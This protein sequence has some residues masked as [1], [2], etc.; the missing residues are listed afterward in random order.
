MSVMQGSNRNGIVAA[1]LASLILAITASTAANAESEP[2]NSYSPYVGRELPNR[3][4]FGDTHLH[5]ANS[6]DAFLFGARICP[7][8]A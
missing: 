8:V 4:F 3:I 2:P 6:P 7:E 1:V 5:T